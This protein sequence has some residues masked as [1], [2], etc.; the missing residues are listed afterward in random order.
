LNYHFFQEAASIQ[1]KPE[2]KFNLF[3]KDES[4]LAGPSSAITA[5]A[6]ITTAAPQ[7]GSS[8]SDVNR[9]RLILD[10]NLDEHDL[11]SL[12]PPLPHTV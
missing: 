6:T 11:V 5:A 9:R 10:L 4:G 3:G 1:A 7:P 8:L 12:P 2:F